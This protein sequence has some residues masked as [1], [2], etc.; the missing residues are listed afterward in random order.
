MEVSK[1]RTLGKRWNRVF[2]GLTVL[3]I[4]VMYRGSENHLM[5]LILPFYMDH[6]IHVRW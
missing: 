4:I 1:Y 5:Y 2:L 6:A 3:G